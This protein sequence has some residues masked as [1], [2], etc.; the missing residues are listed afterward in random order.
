M[1]TLSED[2][3][4]M[5]TGLAYQDAGDF[6]SI[7]EK[8]TVLGNG[9]ENPGKPNTPVHML[10]TQISGTRAVTKR[11][12]FIS[13]G[14]GLGAPLDYAID[15]CLRQNA[16]I[17]LLIHGSADSE[18]TSALEKKIKN[19]G[20]RYQRIQLEVTAVYGIV[21]YIAKHP[22]LLYLIA[23]PDDDVARVLIEEVLP[24]RR[25]RIQIPVVLIEDQILA[26]LPEQSAA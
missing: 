14:S 5:L 15:A 9:S 21:K 2:L 17:D 3:K 19:A 8:M 12:A 6:L 11:I 16:Q 4:K 20:V 18:K 7:R 24:G 22:S 23:M 25:R 10:E 1:T 26:R 13:N